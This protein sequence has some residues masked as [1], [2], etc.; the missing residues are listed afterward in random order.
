[1]LVGQNP[2]FLVWMGPIRGER[3]KTVKRQEAQ[4]KEVRFCRMDDSIRG[5]RKRNDYE[6]PS[7]SDDKLAGEDERVKDHDEPRFA[8]RLL[9]A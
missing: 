5:V 4:T 2:T 1:M 6:R 3:E 7:A 8:D 9:T